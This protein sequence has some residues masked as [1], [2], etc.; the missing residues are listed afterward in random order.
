MAL[1]D[2]RACNI[3]RISILTSS[4]QTIADLYF[5]IEIIIRSILQSLWFLISTLTSKSAI[6]CKLSHLSLSVALENGQHDFRNSVVAN[7]AKPRAGDMII[8]GDLPGVCKPGGVHCVTIA[9]PFD[10]DNCLMI[11]V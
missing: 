4:L 2:K 6:C 7:T 8:I 10:D 11:V 3:L 1:E 5:N 9:P